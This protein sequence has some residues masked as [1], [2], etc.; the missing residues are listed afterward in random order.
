VSTNL[1]TEISQLQAKARAFA[2]ES[3]APGARLADETGHPQVSMR[4]L[5]DAGLLDDRLPAQ[6]L[7]A[8]YE[9]LGRIDSSIRGAATVQVSLIAKT[10]EQRFGRPRNVARPVAQR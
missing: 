6:A 9:E 7:A 8:V 5:G 3:L 2:L 1:T 10:S 4:Q